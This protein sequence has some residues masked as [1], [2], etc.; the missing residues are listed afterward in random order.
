MARISSSLRVGD[1]LAF[2][3][4]RARIGLEK[5]HQHAQ[6]HRLA[7]PAAAQNAEGLAAIHREAHVLQD[8]AAIKRD[9]H[10]AEGDDRLR[11]LSRRFGRVRIG[12]EVEHGRRISLPDRM[13]GGILATIQVTMSLGFQSLP[14]IGV[15]R[16]IK[17][18]L[19]IL[20]GFYILCLIGLFFFQRS[21]LYFPSHSYV[22]LSEAR[23]NSSFQE[24][25][26]RTADGIDLKAWYAPA[27]TKPF[28]FV[29]FHGNGDCLCDRLDGRR[30]LHPCRL[31][32][33]WLQNTAGIAD[34]PGKPT[35]A[36]L[37]ADATRL[38]L[39]VEGTRSPE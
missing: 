24:I 35:E 38:S 25:S 33:F 39:C 19:A 6:R 18:L 9:A 12:Q 37:Y 27:T 20:A 30:S 14:V 3:M 15:K 34:L 16:R 8:R 32:G 17:R 23:A 1:L 2:D 11:R 26:T 21:F 7:H 22:H 36:G 4:N 13:R 29:F 10:V 28:T 5:A 31:S